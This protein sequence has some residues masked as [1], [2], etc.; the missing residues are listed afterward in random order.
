MRPGESDDR[1]PAGQRRRQRHERHGAER[2]LSA[3]DRAFAGSTDEIIQWT[4]CKWGIDEDWV[5]AQIVNE[6]NWNQDALGDFSTDPN[7][8]APTYPIGNYPAQWGGDRV[9]NGECPESVGLGQVRWLYHTTSVRR[10]PSDHVECIQP[11]LHLCRV[12]CVL[13]GS[14]GWLNNA[15]GRK[16][17]A[18]GDAK[19]CLGVWFSGRWYT[20]KAIAYIDRFDRR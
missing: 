6:S 10:E 19:G 20:D 7:A 4:A 15:E 12:A 11:G 3:G 13:R 9:H 17:Y 5:R 18:A 16:N 2:R 8:C 14:F 1:E